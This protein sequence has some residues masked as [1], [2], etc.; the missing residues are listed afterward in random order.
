VLPILSPDLNWSGLFYFLPVSLLTAP[1][2]YLCS[3]RRLTYIFLLLLLAFSA[4]AQELA[5]IEDE[6]VSN[7]FGY[8]LIGGNYVKYEFLWYQD[9]KNQPLNYSHRPHYSR[10]NRQENKITEGY[11]ASSNGK[12]FFINRNYEKDT[13]GQLIIK[14]K[15][16]LLLIDPNIPANNDTLRYTRLKQ[17]SGKDFLKEDSVT[18]GTLAPYSANNSGSLWGNYGLGV[19]I[20]NDSLLFVSGKKR[21]ESWPFAEWNCRNLNKLLYHLPKDYTGNFYFEPPL[22]V[23]DGGPRID[24]FSAEI[25]G[26]SLQINYCESSYLFDKILDAINGPYFSKLNAFTYFLDNI[27][28]G[29]PQFVHDTTGFTGG[30]YIYTGD[31]WFKLAVKGRPH[32]IKVFKEMKLF[33]M[34]VDT[35][36]Y[37]YP[38]LDSNSKKLF[39]TQKINGD[40]GQLA[41]DSLHTLFLYENPPYMES[42]IEKQRLYYSLY[43]STNIYPSKLLVNVRKVSYGMMGN[44]VSREWLVTN[45]SEHDK[46]DEFI[47]DYIRKH[48]GIKHK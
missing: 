23:M 18:M 38:K 48:Y 42:G 43:N 20:Y 22:V 13:L 4:K 5:G 19:V 1:S 45:K 17:T 33:E 29:K 40:T 39:F 46:Y 28:P 2:L 26:K 15:D 31:M 6:W 9:Y 11:I 44:T 27:M 3:M 16:T 12:V 25:H 21:I 41:V 35:T 7:K 14:N 34:N 37:G 36:V 8:L 32:L 47:R 10:N 24:R 30:K